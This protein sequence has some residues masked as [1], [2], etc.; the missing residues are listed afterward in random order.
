ML[1]V[2]ACESEEELSIGDPFVVV[3]SWGVDVD[4]EVEVDSLVPS[5][6]PDVLDV[7]VLDD[8]MLTL[9]AVELSVVVVVKVLVVVDVVVD[10]GVGA[11]CVGIGVG[12][13]VGAGVG[14]TDVGRCVVGCCRHK[15]NA[16]HRHVEI[17]E[18]S[19]AYY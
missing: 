15:A 5:T 17:P 19:C 1:E 11:T 10:A 13:G 6:V 9:L 14:G 4:A 8:A 3:T 18:Q 12:R 2:V 7:L 16:L